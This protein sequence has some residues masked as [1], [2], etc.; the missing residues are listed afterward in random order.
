[1]LMRL[2]N[3][4]LTSAKFEAMVLWREERVLDERVGML[5]GV[6]WVRR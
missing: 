4:D 1:M 5:E 6:R 3:E 2:R